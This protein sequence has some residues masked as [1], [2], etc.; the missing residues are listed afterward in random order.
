MSFSDR[1]KSTAQRLITK[2]GSDIVLIEVTQLAYDPILGDTST[3]ETSYP[4][5]GAIGNFNTQDTAISETVKEG[6]LSVL[7]RTELNTDMTWK[8][9]YDSKR[10]EIINVKRTVAQNT[11]ILQRFHIRALDV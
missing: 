2:F 1:A 7:I 6:D 9:D 5:K 11:E 10:W 8:I 4:V 3:S